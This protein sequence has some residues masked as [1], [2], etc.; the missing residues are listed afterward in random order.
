MHDKK[1]YSYY[2]S[3]LHA[4]H[5]HDRLTALYYKHVSVSLSLSVFATQVG[6]QTGEKIT[7]LYASETGNTAELAKNVQVRSPVFGPQLPE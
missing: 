5:K 2:Y 7:I 1:A 6:E 3:P 4:Q